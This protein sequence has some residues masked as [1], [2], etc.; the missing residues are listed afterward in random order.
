MSF[1]IAVGVIWRVGRHVPKTSGSEGCIGFS[2]FAVYPF[3]EFARSTLNLAQ[4]EEAVSFI[5][6]LN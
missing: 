3:P 1:S 2:D 6:F 4:T 5:K